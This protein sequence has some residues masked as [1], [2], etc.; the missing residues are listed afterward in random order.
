[1]ALEDLK[2]D[3]M[4]V[5]LID[6]LEQG[7]DIGYYGRLVFAMIGRYSGTAMRQR[8]VVCWNR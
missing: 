5:H 8:R 3:D 2:K 7:K 4:M 6:S 1:M